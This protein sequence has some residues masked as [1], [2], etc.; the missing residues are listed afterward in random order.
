MSL[1]KENLLDHFKNPRNYDLGQIAT[2][3]FT[4]QEAN[5]LCGDAICL[6]GLVCEGGLKK[7]VFS[8]KGCVISQATA[9]ILLENC[10]GK[11]VTHILGLTDLDLLALI[12]MDLGPNRIKCATLSLIALQNGISSVRSV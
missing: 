6:K 5:L 2:P 1:Y 3:N 12:G 8:G 7:A 4:H 10:V 11:E 9:S